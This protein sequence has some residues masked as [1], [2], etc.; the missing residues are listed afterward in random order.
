MLLHF[1]FCDMLGGFDVDKVF[2][3]LL[4][5]CGFH[6]KLNN[7]NE[8]LQKRKFRNTKYKRFWLKG[9]VM[10]KPYTCPPLP[11][12]EGST[13]S[14][15]EL[16]LTQDCWSSDENNDTDSFSPSQKQFPFVVIQFKQH[17]TVQNIA[18]TWILK[19]S[20]MHMSS[21][22]LVE[23]IW[24]TRAA[25]KACGSLEQWII[26]EVNESVNSCTQ[27]LQR[28]VILLHLS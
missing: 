16:E 22:F 23:T 12:S 14:S 21:S 15:L 3:H 5:L 11:W 10:D 1:I 6:E 13:C 18:L 9:V 8:D 4:Q 27:M 25:K 24:P 17:C 26:H 19:L 20:K 2:P 7:K 28:F